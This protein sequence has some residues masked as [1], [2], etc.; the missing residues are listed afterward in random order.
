MSQS[1]NIARG[2][3]CVDAMHINEVGG[4]VLILHIAEFVPYCTLVP[5]LCTILNYVTTS[6]RQCILYT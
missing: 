1:F 4:L 5:D 3:A 2:G 6:V